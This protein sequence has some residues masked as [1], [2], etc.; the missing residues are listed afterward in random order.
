MSVTNQQLQAPSLRLALPVINA[1]SLQ[2]EGA[3][4]AVR[5]G[6]DRP[7]KAH[8]LL[9][10]NVLNP[11]IAG[12]R[13]DLIASI[14]LLRISQA[15]GIELDEVHVDE[16]ADFFEEEVIPEIS[17]DISVP[18]LPVGRI[19]I[20]S[21]EAL[22]IATNNEEAVVSRLLA[23]RGIE[24]FHKG[25]VIPE[26]VWLPDEKATWVWVARSSRRHETHIM[27]D[28]L[29][30][31]IGNSGNPFPEH[32]RFGTARVRRNQRGA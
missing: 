26:K 25:K 30:A 29:E 12:L 14:E 27:L 10:R 17:D 7:S 21:G 4:R 20:G 5:N 28:R 13:S 23:K 8:R 6:E 18:T 16:T 1:G 3:K 9:E 19:P 22:A 31:S 2:L 24:R 15:I 32:M 11:I